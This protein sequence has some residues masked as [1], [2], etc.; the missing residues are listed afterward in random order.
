MP[1]PMLNLAVCDLVD[2]SVSQHVSRVPFDAGHI[3]V[4]ILLTRPGII[5]FENSNV[6]TGLLPLQVQQITLAD[7][8]QPAARRPHLEFSKIR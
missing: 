1:T 6:S 7:D 4:S 8:F 3:E 5:Y 2:A